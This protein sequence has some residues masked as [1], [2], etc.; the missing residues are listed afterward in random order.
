MLWRAVPH[1]LIHATGYARS[2]RHAFIEY[3]S[4]LENEA[5]VTRLVRPLL[6]KFDVNAQLT[7]GDGGAEDTLLMYVIQC[8]LRSA[9]VGETALLDLL[10]DAEHLDV[11]R[12][13]G[14]G[15]TAL[16]HVARCGRSDVNRTT[17]IIK[18]LGAS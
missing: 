1:V 14:S 18:I 8:T 11:S 17:E 5:D 15:L 2:P 7:D 13:N 12:A 4:K 9:S 3:V 16:H 10:L 6:A